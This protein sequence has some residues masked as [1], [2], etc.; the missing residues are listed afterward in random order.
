MLRVTRDGQI[1]VLRAFGNIV[2]TGLDVR[3]RTIYL[4]EAG[5]VPHRP[6][7][8][9]VV[10]FRPNSPA[11]RDVAAGSRLLVDVEFGRGGRL[12]A[13]SQGDFPPGSPEG[14][15]ARPDTGALVKVNRD[16][17]FTTVVARSGA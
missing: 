16:G 11:V 10:A 2:P 15:P 17:H 14:S 12:Y 9:T 3:G 1:T 7:N 5:P 4:A 13:L 8:G 6:E